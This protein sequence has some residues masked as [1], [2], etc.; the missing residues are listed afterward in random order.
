M[1]EP[2]IIDLPESESDPVVYGNYETE[3]LPSL[4]ARIK[5]LFID[6][7]ILLI[8][9]ASAS[10]IIDSV[11]GASDFVRGF[12]LVFMIYLYD[13]LFTS[14]TGSTLGHKVMGL[15]VVRYDN[16]EKR[17]SIL[18]G[19][20]R[21]MVKSLLGWLSFITISANAEKRALHDLAG[22]SILLKK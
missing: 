4:L 10:V 13:P 12:I 1:S 15:K 11:G 9:F 18:R 16:P 8:V 17:I 3:E 22:G 5:A 21:F 7:L 2:P 6:F 19:F 14:L 20:L